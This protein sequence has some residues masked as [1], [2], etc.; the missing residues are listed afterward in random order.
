MRITRFKTFFLPFW[1][2]IALFPALCEEELHETSWPSPILTVKKEQSKLVYEYDGIKKT[3][4]DWLERIKK[5]CDFAKKH[6]QL[7]HYTLILDGEMTV[8]EALPII[9][10]LFAYGATSLDVRVAPGYY[11]HYDTKLVRV[12]VLPDKQPPPLPNR[13][14]PPQPIPK[15]FSLKD[16]GPHQEYVF[17]DGHKRKLDVIILYDYEDKDKKFNLEHFHLLHNEDEFLMSKKSLFK[18]IDF[19]SD[20]HNN[21]WFIIIDKTKR[22]TEKRKVLETLLKARKAYYKIL[23]ATEEEKAK[24]TTPPIKAPVE[25]KH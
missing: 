6:R 24:N 17:P 25:Q 14:N 2:L 8:K 16:I 11:V 15:D 21:T 12:C 13:P 10:K 9:R 18:T 7:S 3:R 5:D 1:L 23:K 20:T 22:F 19:L 4:S